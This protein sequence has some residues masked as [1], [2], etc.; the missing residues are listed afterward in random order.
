MVYV[1][2][3]ACDYNYW[4][5]SGASGWAYKDVLSYFKRMKSWDSGGHGGDPMWRGTNEPLHIIRG[6][7]TNPLFQAFVDAGQQA[8]YQTT[9][10]YNGEQQEGFGPM[11]QTV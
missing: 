4:E 2:G 6:P 1:R 11:E 9:N 5:E 7:R 10:D 8:G 3:H